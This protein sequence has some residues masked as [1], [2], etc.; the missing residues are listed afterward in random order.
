M[1]Q[2]DTEAKLVIEE[3]TSMYGVEN[4]AEAFFEWEYANKYH[5]M[6]DGARF[7][8]SLEAVTDRDGDV[9]YIF[10]WRD[11]AELRAQ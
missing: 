9:G 2:L 10:V 11:P 6:P 8:Q 1:N 4:V 5:Q 3:C 7:L